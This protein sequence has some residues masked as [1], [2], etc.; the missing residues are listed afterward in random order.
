MNKVKVKVIDRSE[1]EYESK[2][3]CEVGKREAHM[4]MENVNVLV[5][6]FGEEVM[7]E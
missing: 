5:E 7:V 4:T 6:Q 2:E 3:D 1:I